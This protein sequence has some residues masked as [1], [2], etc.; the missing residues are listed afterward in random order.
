[1]KK[2]SRFNKLFSVNN[3]LKMPF[4]QELY[5]FFT[6]FQ[7]ALNYRVQLLGILLLSIT[8]VLFSCKKKEVTPENK[9]V[10]KELFVEREPYN[11]ILG[12]HAISGS[13]KL[14][15]SNSLIEQAQRI[16][17]MGSNILKITLAKN[18][19]NIYGINE[20]TPSRTTLDL[21]SNNP[22][23]KVAC[24]MDFKYIFFWVHTMTNV[25]WKNNITPANEKILYNEMY[26]FATY[27]LNKYNNTGKTFLIG[28]WEGD[29]LLNANYDANATPSTAV[30]NNMTK[31][32]QIRQKAIDDA[33]AA[34]KSKNVFM[35]HYIEANLVQKGMNGQPCVAESVI[36]NV[37]VDLIS[38]S[39]YEAIKGKTYNRT[40]S[41]LTAIFNY[42]ESKLKPKP[43]LPF[44]RRVFIGEYGYQANA[45]QPAT[46][47]EQFD[48]T[49]EMMRISFE[50]NIPFSLHWQMYNNEYDDVTKVSKQMSLI[51]E[52]GVK[53]KVYYLHESFYQKMNDYLKEEKQKNNV[54]PTSEQFR[55]KAIE[56]LATL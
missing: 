14:T 34:T 26:N 39:S 48:E 8:S 50:L 18:S 45:S 40:K 23:Y 24:E 17:E 38:Y 10:L 11:F 22:E 56:V 43:S 55:T 30:L 2:T 20:S 15:N 25:D 53:T 19:T 51:N 32:F 31:W 44:S 12:T 42:L 5:L 46:L 33:K 47:Q 49:K 6:L 27:I 13:Y 16:R 21:F 7:K 35:Y 1:M 54:Y 41:D 36:P 3:H 29:W 4:K 37:N 9:V 52:Q 28:N